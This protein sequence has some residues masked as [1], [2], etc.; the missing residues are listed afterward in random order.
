MSK[1]FDP[2]K[3]AMDAEAFEAGYRQGFIDRNRHR[4]HQYSKVH[5]HDC[6]RCGKTGVSFCSVYMCEVMEKLANP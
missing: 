4:S 5:K 3:K 1:P 6:S 2:I